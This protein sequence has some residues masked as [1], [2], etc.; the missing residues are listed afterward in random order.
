MIYSASAQ[1]IQI[2]LIVSLLIWLWGAFVVFIIKRAPLYHF[3]AL[4]VIYHFIGFVYRPFILL[5]TGSSNVWDWIGVFPGDAEIG[6]AI[7]II[8]A[9]YIAFI[10]GF[11]F[12]NRR[13][14]PIRLFDKYDFEAKRFNI[15]LLLSIFALIVGFYALSIT[16]GDLSYK[17]DGDV[18]SRAMV[19]AKGA[20]ISDTS[21]YVSLFADMLGATI[22]MLCV[23]RRTRKIG[24]FL[25]VTYIG[26]R[27]LI[28]AGR[29]SFISV[30]LSFMVVAFA[31]L[32]LRL[33][34]PKFLVIGLL[35]MFLFDVVGSSR[36]AFLDIA[37]GKAS[38][39]DVINNYTESRSAGAGSSDF[40]EFDVATSL[41]KVVPEK[42]DWTYGT[43]YFRLIVW[44]IP[45]LFWPDK[46]VVTSVVNLLNYGN[47]YALTITLYMD[48]YMTGG[49]IIMFFILFGISYALSSAYNRVAK[50]QS[51][52]AL[53]IYTASLSFAPILFRDGPV[54]Y[55]YFSLVNTFFIY[56]MCT[57]AKISRIAPMPMRTKRVAI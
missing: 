23:I 5:L 39:S 54:P 31:A 45:R 15:F 10:L 25:V 16:F 32:R 29:S 37:V 53:L 7:F 11:L 6:R 44:P 3:A 9:G 52:K 13:R 19:D 46:P 30:F 12:S 8:N 4:F 21:G 56:L 57:C 35:V 20:H 48:S 42:T 40:A 55:L 49:A 22:V 38:V 2:Y 47:Y 51:P 50:T 33:P 28:G 14:G 26:Y 27:L 24:I 18:G 41:L 36:T 1:I 17:I 43:Q 34:K